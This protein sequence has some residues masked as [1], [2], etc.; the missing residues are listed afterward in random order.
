M[1][2]EEQIL[3]SDVKTELQKINSLVPASYDHIGL[4]YTGSNL[5]QAVYRTGG[6][7]GTIVSTITLAYDGSDNLISVTKT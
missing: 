2:V 4:S 1:G 7:S 6:A 5:T 3:L